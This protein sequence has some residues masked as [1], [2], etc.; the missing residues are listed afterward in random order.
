VVA[1]PSG[2][3]F[4]A[5]RD[6]RTGSSQLYLQRVTGSGS[7][8]GG[9]PVDGILV[10]AD[11]AAS[12]S[13]P[14]DTDG[15][16]GV[17][18]GWNVDGVIHIVRITASGAV[19]AGWPASGFALGAG[20]VEPFRFS[21]MSD[22]AGGLYAL[23]VD[24]AGGV[25]LHR[26]TADGD[27]HPDWPAAG[28]D[29]TVT[30]EVFAFPKLLTDGGSGVIATWMILYPGPQGGVLP[31]THA[32]HVTSEGDLDTMWPAGGAIVGRGGSVAGD[33]AG[34]VLDSWSPDPIFSEPPG[35]ARASRMGGDANR[36]PGWDEGGN[37]ACTVELHQSRP[38]I[39]ADGEGGAFLAWID[40]RTS[41]PLLYG[42]RLTASGAF[43]EGW[44]ETGSI[45][46]P[47]GYQPSDQTLVP[48]GT[49]TAIVVW[50]DRRDGSIDIYAEEAVPGPAGPPASD[51]VEGS[52]AGALAI[53]GVRP[54]PA[55]GR[56]RAWLSL[57]DPSPTTLELIDLAG[58]VIE[59]RRVERIVPP[60]VVV[61]F[62]ERARLTPGVY[63]LRARQ[64]PATATA[65]V[66]IAR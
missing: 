34:G 64:G 20:T 55:R 7:I 10:A 54:N 53:A 63:W 25:R 9:W 18:L 28:I 27:T 12:S 59:T 61:A 4:V 56:F 52:T 66:V 40:S 42:M 16:G 41:P 43:A 30:S 47:D 5:W 17:Y 46:A 15:N 3:A 26:W 60:G 36:P 29:V 48:T 6:W 2:G 33:G 23:R 44:P 45:A 51:A 13:P 19:A 65:R 11:P 50:K 32:T 58:R 24:P 31:E 62:N 37:P 38:V 21:M 1:D 57:P 35:R 22:G 39:A 49:G 8:A 14:I